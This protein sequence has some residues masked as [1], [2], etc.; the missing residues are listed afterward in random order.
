MSWAGAGQQIALLRW[1]SVH[2]PTESWCSERG[3][4]KCETLCE[5]LNRKCE[6]LCGRLNIAAY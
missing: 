3:D 5:R 1:Q 6:T 2:V 4:R